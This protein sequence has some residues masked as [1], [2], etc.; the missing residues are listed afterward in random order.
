MANEMARIQ[1]L[2]AFYN[3]TGVTDLQISIAFKTNNLSFDDEFG[4][5]VGKH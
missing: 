2:D 1:A 4:A 3:E 5:L